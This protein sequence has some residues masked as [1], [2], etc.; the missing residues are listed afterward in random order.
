MDEN[1][2]TA[3]FDADDA[4]TQ[5]LTLDDGNVFDAEE[6]IATEEVDL[7]GAIDEGGRG[8]S[9]RASA[10]ASR[11]IAEFPIDK[12][13]VWVTA[14]LALTILF[15][16]LAGMVYFQQIKYDEKDSDIQG[17]LKIFTDMFK[18]EGE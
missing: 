5:E 10:R 15:L 7:D 9:R 4:T 18:E 3:E 1:A 2:V 12:P 14:V 11:R 6:E 8:S 13:P 17:H 16:M